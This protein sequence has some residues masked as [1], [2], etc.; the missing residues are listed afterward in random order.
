MLYRILSFITSDPIRKIFAIIFA[1]G[2]WIYVAIGNNYTYQRE[3]EVSYA[4]L[5]DSLIMVDS[6]PSV[7][8]AFTGRGGA[9][10]TIWAAPPKALC[11]LSQTRPGTV[12]I[13]ARDL[14]TTVGYGPMRIDFETPVLTISVDR[15]I[16]KDVAVGVPVKG[17]P[18]QGYAIDTISI[19]DKMN[20]S[21][22]QRMLEPVNELSTETLSVRNRAESFERDL[23]LILA[24]PLIKTAQSNV[25]ANVR[26]D[27]TAIQT[28]TN[29]PLVIIHSGDQRARSDKIKLDTLIVEGT[30]RRVKNLSARDIAVR[31][32][33]TE[34]APGNHDL[35]AEIILPPYITPVKS[36]PQRF[37]ITID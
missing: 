33:V 17:T 35:P 30:A 25:K 1:F 36:V 9:L 16:E 14:K 31:I 2:L 8:V 12:R 3:I 4:N 27:Q 24:S 15:M 18:R 5:P 28:L 32:N 19:P 13:P 11:D 37:N 26:I 20:V 6:V 7:T 34:L 29:I 21:G 10:F 22:P 23:K